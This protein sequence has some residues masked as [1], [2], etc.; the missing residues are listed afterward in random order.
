MI[1]RSW[2][3]EAVRP[4]EQFSYWHDAV[5]EAVLS[6]STQGAPTREFKGKIVSVDLDDLRFAKFRSKSHEILRTQQHVSRSKVPCYLISLQRRGTS[7]L[8]Q[9]ND[10]CELNPGEIAIMD[11]ARPFRIAFPGDVE[12]TIAVIPHSVLHARAPWL[13]TR[14][15]RKIDRLFPHLEIVRRYLLRLSSAEGALSTSEANLLTENLCNLIAL[16]TASAEDSKARA[17][18]W[19]RHLDLDALLSYLRRNL[20]EPEL[21]PQMAAEHLGVSVRTVHKRF[22]ELDES[23]GR[24]VLN[25]RLGACR[26]LLKDPSWSHTPIST[27]AYSC[28]FNDLS[29]F[30]RCFKERY[31]MTPR[32]CRRSATS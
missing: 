16:A 26:R 18:A 12:R 27:I 5:C 13:E 7:R 1:T 28:G 23:F 29:H 4:I 20:S 21:S 14:P 25:N 22:S 31:G 8:H 32:E 15:L 2:S 10:S 6:V 24:W 19:T 9:N 30:N 3:T 17:R 11:A